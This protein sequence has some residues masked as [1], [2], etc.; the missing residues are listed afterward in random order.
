MP[1]R[2]SVLCNSR[3]WSLWALALVAGLAASPAPAQLLKQ[4][5]DTKETQRAA[6]KAAFQEKTPDPV[7]FLAEDWRPDATAVLAEIDGYAIDEQE[8][9]LRQA[10]LNLDIEPLRDW[11][12]AGP[13]EARYQLGV[14]RRMVEERLA[15]RVLASLP[16]ADEPMDPT[17][18]AN[19]ERVLLGPVARLVYA[20][21]IV[22]DKVEVRPLDI[23]Y[24]Y[25]T[26]KDLYAG[27]EK[28]GAEARGV[29]QVAPSIEPLLWRK[30][31]VTQ[32]NAS[33]EKVTEKARARVRAEPFPYMEDEMIL[34]RVKDFLFT[35]GEFLTFYPKFAVEPEKTALKAETEVFE[36]ERDIR[37]TNIAINEAVL[38]LLEREG[39]AGDERLVVAREIARD[40]IRANNA[41]TVLRDAQ[42]T[43][44]AAIDQI[45][46]EENELLQP[47][48]GFE[49]WR[50]DATAARWPELTA[51]ERRAVVTA[52][53]DNI[54]DTRDTAN[55]LIEER[56]NIQGAGVLRLPETIIERLL[57]SDEDQF[58]LSFSSLSVLSADDLRNQ[59]GID[60]ADLTLG[61]LTEPQVSASGIVTSFYLADKPTLPPPDKTAVREAAKDRLLKRAVDSVVEQELAAR[62]DEGRLVWMLP[63]AKR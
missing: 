18:A 52:M 47:T 30:H 39:K 54:A 40:W 6:E 9:F 29:R 33:G 15:E 34:V 63:D 48:Q 44:D 16:D 49:V 4:I 41:R 59:Q 51:D 8:L 61:E 12:S 55:R 62:R 7:R 17:E 31:F 46:A 50:L 36:S 37:I 13:A 42:P 21:L 57:E 24:Y 22:R 2:R 38:Q 60:I 20:D 56:I 10:M 1:H 23:A 58:T 26:N 32:T 43:D 45:I 3:R 28:T 35:R 14:V 25:H 11:R 27:D 19:A 53:I 5:D